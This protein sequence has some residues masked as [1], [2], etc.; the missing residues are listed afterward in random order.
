LQDDYFKLRRLI[1]FKQTANP[2]TAI[3]NKSL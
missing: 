2:G 3:T 1:G